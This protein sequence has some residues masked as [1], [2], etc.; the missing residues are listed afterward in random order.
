MNIA[1]NKIIRVLAMLTFIINGIITWH[2]MRE[3]E[4]IATHT[5]GV[6]SDILLKHPPLTNRGMI[7]WWQDNQVRLK[8][9]YNLPKTD[10]NGDFEMIFWDLAGGLK[11]EVIDDSICFPEL[12][13]PA[14]CID[15][16]KRLWV[17]HSRNR[18]LTVV[19][20]NGYYQVKEDGRL[21]KRED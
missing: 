6:F 19:V 21:I 12:K 3:V 5:E 10:E 16:N 17:S 15:K 7:R 9:Q 11:P 4:I 18:G 2:Y 14:N 8:E 20:S 1:R 13:P